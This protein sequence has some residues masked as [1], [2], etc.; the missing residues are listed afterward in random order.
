MPQ[1]R[2]SDEEREAVMT[3]V[4]GLVAQPPRP[5]YVHQPDP[6]RLAVLEGQKLLDQYNCR[7]CHAMRAPRW[8]IEFPPETFPPQPRQPTFPFV[9]HE[10]SAQAIE[11]SRQPDRRGLLRARLTGQPLIG[12]DGRPMVFDDYGDEL[13]DDDQYDPG[14]LEYAFQL[15]EPAVLEGHEYQVGETPLTIPAGLVVAKSPS[16]GGFLA[17]YLLPHVVRRERETNP[18]AKGAEAWGWLPP[19][20][21]GLGQRVQTPWLRNYLLDPR[22]MRPASVMPMPRFALSPLEADRL[23]RYFAAVD[24]VDERIDAAAR[25]NTVYLEQAEREFQQRRAELDPAGSPQGTRFDHAMQILIDKNYCVTC[26]IVGDY[27][28]QTSDRAKAADLAAVHHRLRSDWLRRW[29][30]KPVSLVP[31]T[32]M[33]VNIPYNPDHEHLGGV[34]QALYHG[35]SVEQLDALVDLLLN[36]DNYAASRSGIG[37][38]IQAATEPPP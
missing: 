34:D 20:L 12:D 35:T 29:I 19:P 33:P 36:F 1:F 14:T 11:A 37:T 8:Q 17:N 28:P 27:E 38:Q 6:Q 26:H 16:D 21:Y 2:F 4:L 3:F 7:G 13:F 15:W 31:Y 18:N 32:G 30:G 9:G 23:A 24:G 25:R 22:P 5:R 10:F